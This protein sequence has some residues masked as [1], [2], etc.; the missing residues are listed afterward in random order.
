[1]LAE[2]ETDLL[3]FP[4]LSAPRGPSAAKQAQA[5]LTGRNARRVLFG[6]LNLRTGH[7]VLLVRP[8]QQAR[9]FR[10]AK[11]NVSANRPGTSG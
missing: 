8:K 11:Q 5:S 7:R 4:R 6:A 3:L 10:S 9:D 2:D 1:M